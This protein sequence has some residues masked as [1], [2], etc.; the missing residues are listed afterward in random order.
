MGDFIDLDAERARRDQ[1]DPEFV[2]KDEFGR[3]LYTFA[4]S[5]C[6]P[7]GRKFS[8]EFLAYDQADAED[9]VAGM[10]LGLTYDGQIF[11]QVL[12]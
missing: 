2:R 4:A 10:N 5:Y 9:A 11:S 3:N 8:I 12:P 1:P 6:R 7:D